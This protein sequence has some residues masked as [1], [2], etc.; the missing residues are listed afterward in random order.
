MDFTE[1]LHTPPNTTLVAPPK[2][3]LT[4]L[5][6]RQVALRET[7]DE[8]LEQSM[9]VVEGAMGMLEVDPSVVDEDGNVAMPKVWVDKVKSGEM[10]KHEAQKRLRAAIY[11]LQPGKDAPVGLKIALDIFTGIAKA[12]AVEKGGPKSLN[13]VMVQMTAPMPIFDSMDV[14]E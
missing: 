3:S 7:E 5:E 6:V 9:A 12:R 2:R 1:G 10:S 4:R 8:I 14:D 11:A 13:M